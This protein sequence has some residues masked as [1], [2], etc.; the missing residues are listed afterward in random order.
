MAAR[1]DPM[2]TVSQ[3]KMY[4]LIPLFP[5]GL[6]LL[7]HMELPLHIFE[8]RYKTMIKTCLDSGQAFGIVYFDGTA[9]QKIG[10]SAKIQSVTRQYDDG[11]M[12]ILTRGKERFVIRETD[13]SRPFTQARVM[14]FGD[15]VEKASVDDPVLVADTL[16]LL[17]DMDRLSGTRRDYQAMAE[18]NMALLS[19][20]IPALDG[21][22]AE[23]RQFF[24]ET[25]SPRRR[26]HK[27]K[28][29]LKTVMQRLQ[30][31]GE[32]RTA[33]G[34]NGDLKTLMTRAGLST[35]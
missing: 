27:C 15:E 18:L 11:R 4:P 2:N 8:E 33:I 26:L 5:L 21:F 28:A 30:M 32:I 16:R 19:F 34:G 35:D 25:T 13:E 1:G 20:V 9:I 6:V 10:C 12:D 17:E 23:E 31:N 29:A 24:L 3:D 7:P 14:F 22:T